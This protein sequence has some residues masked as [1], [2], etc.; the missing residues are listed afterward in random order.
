M[1]LF[2]RAGV[3]YEAPDPDKPFNVARASTEKALRQ[4][5][6]D[7]FRE[8]SPVTGLQDTTVP[9][10][11]GTPTPLTDGITFTAGQAINI[12]HGMSRKPKGWLVIDCTGTAHAL[13]NDAANLPTDMVTTHMRL[14]HTG[15]ATTVVKLVFV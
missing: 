9:V 13:I 3:V 7:Q 10:V 15:G 5:D 1:S 8:K 11:R 4:Q 14:K 2:G 6:G 12:A